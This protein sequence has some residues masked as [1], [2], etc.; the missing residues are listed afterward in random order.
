VFLRPVFNLN[1]KGRK[2]HK[3][4]YPAEVGLC[5]FGNRVLFHEP[6]SGLEPRSLPTG[7]I[8]ESPEFTLAKQPEYVQGSTGKSH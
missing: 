5:K 8:R 2:I 7:N 3:L 4:N 1:P 6:A